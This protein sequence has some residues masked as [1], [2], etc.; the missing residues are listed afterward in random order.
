MNIYDEELGKDMVIGYKDSEGA[1]HRTI[2]IE[3]RKDGRVKIRPIKKG[4][5]CYIMREQ[6]T[7]V[8]TIIE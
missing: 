4:E 2:V 3:D 5:P 8:Q 1:I 7:Y 6:I